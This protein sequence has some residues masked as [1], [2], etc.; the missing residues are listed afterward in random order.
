M[1]LAGALLA[2]TLQMHD[3]LRWVD[4]SS[5]VLRTANHA[6]ASLRAAE[7][8]Q[9]GY[10]LTHNPEFASAVLPAIDTARR[11]AADLV[12]LTTDNFEQH[13]R[14]R[15][16]QVLVNARADTLATVYR[17]ARSGAFDRALDSTAS[18]RGL[19]MMQL[20]EAKV[21]DLL[22]DE[23]ALAADRMAEVE[24]LLR[25]IRW[26]VVLGTPLTLMMLALVARSLILRI[27]RPVGE[28]LAVMGELGAG[29]REAR[30][31]GEMGSSEFTRLAGGYNAMA[32][33]LQ[34]A[35]ASQAEAGE[36]LKAANAALSH[37]AETLRERGEVIEILGGMAHRMQA[38]RTDDELAAIIRVFV[39]RVLPHIPGVLFVHNNSRNLLIPTA[40]WGGVE[41]GQ[42]FGQAGF[43]PEECW[44]LR[45][46]QSHYVDEPG[47]DIVCPHVG[48]QSDHYHC[49][50]LLAGGEV[51]GVLY[52]MGTIGT[53]S[54]FRLAVLSENIASALVNH[55]LQRG[56]REQ[57]IRDPL[58]G[59][60]NRRYLEETLALEMA[61]ASRSS[62]PLTVVM[63]DI[64]HFKRFNDEFGHDAGDQVLQTVAGELRRRFRDGD[65]VC[66]FGGEEFVVI[67]PAT[68][69]SVLRARV[70]EVRVAVS[71]LTVRQGE[72]ALGSVTMSFGLASWA[73]GMDREGTAL[74]KAADA[75]LYAAKREG[76]NRV[77]IDPQALAA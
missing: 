14:A 2:V 54:R 41:A 76:R 47:S 21:N 61:R 6:L 15:Q 42:A 73:P 65:V 27:R 74:L 49:E 17:L 34:R 8:G 62:A 48:Q 70:E 58:T 3:N 69:V 4:H 10:T 18:G 16:L 72:R 67:A 5:R 23:R 45:R 75:A 44:A 31:T 7:S 24:S 19:A 66:R 9:R 36:N 40:T 60:F 11:D 51:I 37:N 39:P 29:H 30:V 32:D 43:A 13:E 12:A 20:V 22:L 33:E 57:T 56:L 55:R 64:D 77:M 38:A 46:G 50:P 59:L 28:M 53:E 71:L 35:V 1:I 26:L 68:E 25:T 52:L 63:C